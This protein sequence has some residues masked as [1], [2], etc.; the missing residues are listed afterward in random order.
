MTSR[1]SWGILGLGGIS[2]TFAAGLAASSSAR[3]DAVASRDQG[4]ANA[5]AAQYGVERA[6]GSYAALL[7]DPAVEFVYISTPHHIHV[8]LVVEAAASGKHILCEKPIAVTAAGAERAVKAARDAKV[9]LMEG[10]AFRVHPQTARLAELIAGGEIGDLRMM[11]LDWGFDAGPEPG[12]TYYYRGDLAGGAILDNGCYTVSMAR[13]LA[14]AAAGVGFRDPDR[15]F[16][17]GLLHP[18][19]GID[20]DAAG[21]LWWEGGLS[22][23]IS[24]SFRTEIDKT[25]LLTGSEGFIR[26]PAPYLPLRPDR[27]GGEPRIL[28]ER[29]G[30][31]D[32]QVSIDVSQGAYTIEAD[33]VVDYAR[34]GRTEA[35]E[36]TLDDIL[37]NMRTLDL[38][39]RA[40]GVRLP[41]DADA[42][43]GAP[44]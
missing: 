41:I 28:I 2:H 29:R 23:A 3:L 7:A 25:V 15:V 4:K 5:F 33:R 10:F 8:D 44:R 40:V 34:E 31:P 11:K 16:G 38:W 17:A 24:G 26:L 13:R 39:R 19:E 22:A 20:L 37:G 1:A 14:G 6:Y 18:T 35:P 43:R 30:E 42:E 12:A 21:L 9:F 32:R 36:Y 27:F